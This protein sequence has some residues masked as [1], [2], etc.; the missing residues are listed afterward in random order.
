MYLTAVILGVVIYR[1]LGSCPARTVTYS[2]LKTNPHQ[3]L[4]NCPQV[5]YTIKHARTRSINRV[6]IELFDFQPNRSL[7]GKCTPDGF[8]RLLINRIRVSRNL[9][10]LVVSQSLSNG[11]AP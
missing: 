8:D 4:M 2:T 10:I 5:N 6:H 7:L 1:M 9:R 11:R 3:L